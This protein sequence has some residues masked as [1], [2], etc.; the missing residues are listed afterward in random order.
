MDHFGIGNGVSGAAHVYFHGARR[1]GRTLSLVESVKDGDRLVFLNAREGHRVKSLCKDRGVDIEVVVCKPSYPE[2]L[3]S[4]GTPQNHGRTIFDHG[5]VEKFYLD[6]IN[7]ANSELERL[8]CELSGRG[9]EHII[10]KRKCEEIA[11]WQF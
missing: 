8:Q 4:L 10:T 7:R 3:L 2:I 5:W 11:K 1:T 9:E 6:A